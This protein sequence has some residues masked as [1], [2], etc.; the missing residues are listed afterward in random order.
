MNSLS[1]KFNKLKLTKAGF[2]YSLLTIFIGIAAVNTGNNLLYVLLS[3]LLSFMWLS[4]LFARINLRQLWVEILPPPEA[5]AQKKA[6]ALIRLNNQKRFPS[7]LIK[8]EITFENYNSQE[9]FTVLFPL[10]KDMVEKTIE[11]FPKERGKAKLKIRS[12]FS[13]Y[14]LAL[15]FLFRKTE[16]Q[17]EFTI[18]PQPV[19]YKELTDTRLLFQKPGEKTGKGIGTGDFLGLN[20]YFL[21]APRKYIHWKS[22]AKRDE[23]LIKELADDLAIPQLIELEKLP[24]RT[25][26]EKLGC[27][28]YLILKL[29]KIGLPY[30]LN[31]FGMLYPIGRGEIHRQRILKVL[32]YYGK[33][34]T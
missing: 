26:E 2:L 33:E 28:V 34:K 14:P 3:L 24:G 17:T 18:Y 23:L 12:I 29:E 10:V 13:N 1:R 11:I 25:L 5:F 31:L 16:C 7:F 4:G 19:A 21:G 6:F 8:I 20:P 22:L 15:F 30:G 32:A 9:N 27:A